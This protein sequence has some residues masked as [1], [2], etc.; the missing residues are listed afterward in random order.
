MTSLRFEVVHS[1]QVECFKQWC[2]Q[3]ERRRRQF[4]ANLPED[5][6]KRW[7]GHETVGG[8]RVYRPPVLNVSPI[9]DSSGQVVIPAPPPLSDTQAKDTV[10]LPRLNARNLE[11]AEKLNHTTSSSSRDGA[12]LRSSPSVSKTSSAN[13]HRPRGETPMDLP[14]INSGGGAT[15]PT[16]AL[17]NRCTPSSVFSRG[18]SS[19]RPASQQLASGSSGRMAIHALAEKLSRM[20]R[21]VEE[22]ISEEQHISR[23]L[24][25][26][27]ELIRDQSRVKC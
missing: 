27:K 15:Q 8:R 1:D 16:T 11:M 23:T 17:A 14:P 26:L 9:R 24:E 6:R 5:L 10:P 12:T 20:E 4:V 7:A 22:T 2:E 3:E 13:G 25:E 19:L 21:K 18:T